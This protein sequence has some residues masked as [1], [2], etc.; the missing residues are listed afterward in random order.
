MKI[1]YRV[2]SY[3]EQG[4][5]DKEIEQLLK[6]DIYFFRT[7]CSLYRTNGDGEPYLFVYNN[8]F[9]DVVVYTF[10][11]RLINLPFVDFE[12]SNEEFY[13]IITPYGFGGPL[14]DDANDEV[15]QGFREAFDE[16]CNKENIISEFIRFNPL[17]MNHKYIIKFLDIINDRETVY[18]DLTLDREELINNYHINHKRNL[19]KA[20]KNNLEFKILEKENAIEHISE[21][22]TLYKE[23]MDKL[24]A[25]SYYYFS[26]EY[27]RDLLIGLWKNSMIGAVFYEG[28]MISAALCMYEGGYLHYHLGCSKKEFLHLGTNIYQFHNIALWGKQIGCHTFHLGGGHVGRD[29]LFQFKH[30]FNPSGLLNFY[31]GRKV[32]DPLKYKFL[33]EKWEEYYGQKTQ[34]NFFPAYRCK[35]KTAGIVQARH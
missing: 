29:S 33:V 8:Q 23:T 17:L 12:N 10:I 4:E 5:W 21:F 15:L 11:K 16:Y 2:L 1:L 14:Y 30:R 22:F 19:N 18:I 9:G 7:Y 25:S 34:N 3:K 27:I 20:I 35:P 26:E 13:D 31:I 24:K 32:H 6:K 28:K